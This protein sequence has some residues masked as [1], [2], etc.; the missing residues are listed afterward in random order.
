MIRF[1]AV[2]FGYGKRPLFEG[3]DLALEP[4]GAIGLLGLNGAGKTSLLKLAA[5]ALFPSRGGIRVFGAEPGKRDAAVLS[6]IFFVPEDPWV[7]ALSAD[8]WKRR[9]GAFRPT[10]DVA[11]LDS[12]LEEFG[13]DRTKPLT[14]LSYGQKKKFA[15]A[16]AFA[17]GAR[18]ILLDE[19][20]NGLD[21]PSKAQFRRALSMAIGEDKA[22]VV[23][24]HQARDLENLLD[25]VVIVHQGRTLAQLGGQQLSERFSTKHLDELP[26]KNVVWAERDALGWSAVLADGGGGADLELVFTAAVSEPERFLT[27]LRGESL[28][29]WSPEQRPG[30]GG[31]A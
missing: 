11:L 5:G 23:S 15:V 10:L 19:P 12:T 26:G 31:E 3:L 22:I 16:A 2:T 6:D 24:T 4:G 27:A 8:A 1:D 14:K 7:P 20:T 30:K 28:E 25:P 29:T 21:I 18:A 13:V 9:Y 17:S